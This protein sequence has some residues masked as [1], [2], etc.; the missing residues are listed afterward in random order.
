MMD[1]TTQQ[2]HRGAKLYNFANETP[3]NLPRHALGTCAGTASSS[4]TRSVPAAAGASPRWHGCGDQGGDLL[5][6]GSQL[7]VERSAFS[8][9]IRA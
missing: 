3:V 4:E 6:E 9:V 2:Y 8:F 7:I 5:L 1:P